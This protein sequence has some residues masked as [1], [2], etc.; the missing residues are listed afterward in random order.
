MT[1]NCH[2]LHEWFN[3]LRRFHFPFDKDLPLIPQNGIYILFEQGEAFDQMDRVVRVG[4][5][6]GNNQLQF[7]LCQHFVDENKDRSI[8]RKNIGRCFLNKESHSY[9]KIW[10]LDF[11]TRDQRK[12]NPHLIDRILQEQLEKRISRYIQNNMT[13]SVIEVN[14]KSERLRLESRIV[15]TVSLCK[16][17]KPSDNWL[18]QHS[19]KSRIKESGLWQVN[20]LYKTPLNADDMRKLKALICEYSFRDVLD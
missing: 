11:T 7:R 3:S 6:T 1:D 15:S 10:E 19:P 13:F 2:T 16:N 14:H 12:T 9:L 8:F 20:E 4:T 18:G 5:H 17:C